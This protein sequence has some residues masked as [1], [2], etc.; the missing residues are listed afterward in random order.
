MNSLKGVIVA[1]LKESGKISI[2]KICDEKL[3][4]Q[5]ILDSS[6][7]TSSGSP[8]VAISSDGCAVLLSLSFN[9]YEIWE[10]G[11][12]DRWELLLSGNLDGRILYGCLT[13]TQNSRS[14][15]LAT[16][17]SGCLRRSFTR[18]VSERDSLL[19]SIH[20]ENDMRGA[21]IELPAPWDEGEIIYADCNFLICHRGLKIVFIDVSNGKVI[22]S[23]Y[24]GVFDHYVF[25]AQK[26]VLLL[27]LGNIINCFKIHNIEKYVPF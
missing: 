14:F 13:G 5:Q 24:R 7:N 22:T 4:P 19:S 11:C 20:F 3:C 17:N 16:D 23:I 12:E 26:R 8:N 10:I 27:F 15:L 21:V 2:S 18:Y 25:S 6:F 9:S 1:K